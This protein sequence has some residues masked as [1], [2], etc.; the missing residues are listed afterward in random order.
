MRD[1]VL[2]TTL[3]VSDPAAVLRRLKASNAEVERALA[4]EHGPEAPRAS[5]HASVRRWLATVGSAADDLTALWSLRRGGEPPWI[6]A[7][8]RIRERGDPLSRADLAITGADLQA[9]GTSGPR[10]GQTL[11][12]LLDRVL[13]EPA[14]NTRDTLLSLARKMP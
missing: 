8:R 14:L 2:L 7:M 12:A 13:E 10:I 9:L 4:M 11:A 3:L 5:D 6:A 1:P